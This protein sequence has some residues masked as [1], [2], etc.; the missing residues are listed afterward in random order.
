[1]AGSLG[2][3]S[4]V[5]T[6]RHRCRI[7]A[8]TET[9][10]EFREPVQAWATDAALVWC[11]VRPVRGDEVMQAGRV[12]ADVTHTVVMRHRDGLTA[13][14]RLVWLDTGDVLNVVSVKPMV[15]CANWLEVWCRCEK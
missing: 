5:G 6:L 13:K 8:A 12:Q 9:L 11:E 2:G 4:T 7:E 3:K 10:S 15:G 14:Q 1:M